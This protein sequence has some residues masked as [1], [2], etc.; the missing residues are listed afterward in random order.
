VRIAQQHTVLD[1]L[2]ANLAGKLDAVRSEVLSGM[3][4]IVWPEGANSFSINPTPKGNGVTPIKDPLM[5]HLVG[6]NW[7]LEVVLKDARIPGPVDAFRNEDGLRV[8]LEWETG[9]V[10]SS[11]RVL[12]KM[13]KA[14][15]FGQIDVGF[16]IVSNKDFARYLT[17]RV[18]TEE[19]IAWTF[20]M[21]P[22][23]FKHGHIEVLV[24]EADAL[25]SRA[26]LIPKQVV[27]NAARKA[28][29]K[30]TQPFQD[31]LFQAANIPE[32]LGRRTKSCKGFSTKLE[33]MSEIDPNSLPDVPQGFPR[34]LQDFESKGRCN[35]K[36]FHPPGFPDVGRGGGRAG[37]GG[38]TGR[39]GDEISA[40][41]QIPA[42]DR[43]R[44]GRAD[45]GRHPCG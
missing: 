4:R 7:D 33:S 35:D 29:K 8:C 27:G 16:L 17:D 5:T 36:F 15:T 39:N 14:L 10:A 37:A 40:R 26:P 28:A 43:S 44:D 6:K 38:G 18:G 11:Y 22:H 19:E 31:T 32:D 41:G 23:L 2:P 24:M 21:L 42:P 25:D 3:K 12:L 45:A 9:N 20:E 1:A 13:M 30:A 34:G